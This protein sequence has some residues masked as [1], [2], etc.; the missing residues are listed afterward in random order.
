MSNSLFQAPAFDP[1]RER[2]R[3]GMLIAVAAG[4]VLLGLLVFYFRNWPEEHAVNKFFSALQHKDYEAAYGVWFA[5][6]QWKQHPQQ[7]GK[8]TYGEFYQDWGPGG[9]WGTINSFHVEG[10]QAPRG[11]SS[12]VVVL[13]SVNG[14]AE[15]A[16]IWVE[17]ST[18]QLTFSP[19]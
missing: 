9:E 3:T 18:K 13:V 16:R 17:K 10:G 12:G 14:R 6:P 19:Y 11:G 8:Y 15:R 1:A 2:R 5:D 4:V 7:Y